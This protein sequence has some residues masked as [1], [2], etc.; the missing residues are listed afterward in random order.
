MEDDPVLKVG[1]TGFAFKEF[2][3][4]RIV[5]TKENLKQYKRKDSIN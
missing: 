5:P 2:T 3:H 4:I 1:I